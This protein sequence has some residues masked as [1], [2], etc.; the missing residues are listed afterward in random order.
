MGN[1]NYIMVYIRSR[2]DLNK[3]IRT[4]LF[5]EVLMIL[6][7]YSFVNTNIIEDDMN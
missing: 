1:H 4:R 3:L 5:D 6:R 7:D 2:F